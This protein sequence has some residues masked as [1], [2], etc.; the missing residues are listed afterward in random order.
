[1]APTS[2]PR[3]RSPCYTNT[4]ELYEDM[5][6]ISPNA[7]FTTRHIFKL[8]PNTV[9]DLDAMEPA[10]EQFYPFI[11]AKSFTTIQCGDTGLVTD[12]CIVR[13]G[14]YG[15]NWGPFAG[16]AFYYWFMT[17]IQVKGI[18]FEGQRVN[19]VLLQ[20]K[21][22]VTFTDCI[23]RH[24][25][26]SGLIVSHYDPTLGTAPGPDVLVV[27][28][29]NCLFEYIAQPPHGTGG[30]EFEG[31]VRTFT[32]NHHLIFDS[33]VFRHNFFPGTFQSPR[34]WAMKIAGGTLELHNSCFY[35]N[36]FIG[37]SMIEAFSDTA[38]IANGNFAEPPHYAPIADPE[39]QGHNGTTT[40]VVSSAAAAVIYS[41]GFIARS[42]SVEPRTLQEITCVD[43]SEPTC[44][45]TGYATPVVETN[46]NTTTTP[47]NLQGNR[48]SSATT[49]MRG[50]ELRNVAFVV[51]VLMATTFGCLGLSLW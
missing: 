23:W 33:C 44:T 10:A 37:W 16:L 50:N 36:T 34:G 24:Q 25:R 28:F 17:G 2:A 51:L 41:C 42:S 27:K 22:D 11:T 18:I 15:F 8:C 20:A 45:S 46:N 43:A 30:T 21:G 5:A 7:D 6:A 29:Q 38:V 13:N 26:G 47:D 32:P 49:M 31:L 35:N 3:E 19:S 40:H 14:H 12:N 39:W 4:K 1:M 48:P 9:I